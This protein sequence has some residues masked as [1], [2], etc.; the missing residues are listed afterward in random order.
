MGGPEEEVAD[1]RYDP[2]SEITFKNK[3]VKKRDRAGTQAEDSEEEKDTVGELGQPMLKTAGSKADHIGQSDL[4][5][6]L[7]QFGDSANRGSTSAPMERKSK[8]M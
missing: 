8:V 5:N 4:F 7:P 1:E 6:D 2:L 3:S